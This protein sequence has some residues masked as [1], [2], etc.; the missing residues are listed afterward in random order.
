M[1]T[2]VDLDPR[3]LAATAY[4]EGSSKNVFEEMA[5]IANVLVRQQKARGHASASAFIKADKTFAFAAHDGNERYA[6]LMAA[7]VGDINQNAGMAAAV[8]AAANALAKE[9]LDDAHGAYCW[10]GADI[11]TNDANPAKV[12][13][14]IHFTDP[15]HKRN[16]KDKEL[17]G[18]TWWV[19]A[20][21]SVGLWVG[22]ALK[23]KMGSA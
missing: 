4:G 9:P 2:A 7:T 17:P 23:L 14:G 1:L 21:E 20:K 8:A 6:K 5:A 18:A 22:P 10:D 11:K 19:D 3:T 12:L 15:Q 13:G 16:I